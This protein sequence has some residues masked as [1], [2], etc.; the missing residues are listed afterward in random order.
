VSKGNALIVAVNGIDSRQYNVAEGFVPDIHVELDLPKYA[1]LLS[2]RNFRI[3][4]I[5]GTEATAQ[6]VLDEMR[7]A[8]NSVEPGDLFVFVFSGHGG[9]FVPN[10][11]TEPINAMFLFDRMLL[12]KELHAIWN[13]FCAGARVVFLDGSCHSESMLWNL[14]LG[15]VL[16]PSPAAEEMGTLE[17]T[18]VPLDAMQRIYGASD[19]IRERYDSLIGEA[20]ESLPSCAVAELAAC[21][22]GEV[23]ISYSELGSVFCDAIVK[24]M[25]AKTFHTY[26]DFSAQVVHAVHRLAKNQTPILGYVGKNTREL[27]SQ[28][29]LTV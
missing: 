25:A 16:S 9:R 1:S 10:H 11:G 8:A 29:P 24:V 5:K 15:E 22:N 18:S 7:L 19:A 13:A 6:R 23:A 14:Q 26:R 17:T 28:Y 4:Q 27:L 20:A 2:E 21:G 3:T 12:N